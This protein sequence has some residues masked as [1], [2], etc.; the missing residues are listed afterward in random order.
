MCLNPNPALPQFTRSTTFAD[1]LKQAAE[2]F[3]Q[4]YKITAPGMRRPYWIENLEA[5]N[6]E[7]VR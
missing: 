7:T 5:V 1:G 6:T 3:R 2:A 4:R